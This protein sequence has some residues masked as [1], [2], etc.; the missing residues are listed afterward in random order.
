MVTPLVNCIEGNNENYILIPF[1]NELI[2]RIC[3]TCV[4]PVAIRVH[5]G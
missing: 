4:L 1:D 2:V 5:V 3:K